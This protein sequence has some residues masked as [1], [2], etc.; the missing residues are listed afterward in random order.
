M[1]IKLYDY[2]VISIGVMFTSY[3]I[4]AI[5]I[6]CSCSLVAM[7]CV[8]GVLDNCPVFHVVADAYESVNQLALE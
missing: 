8:W 6:I 4:Q 1:T 3:R 2:T 5:I 7:L